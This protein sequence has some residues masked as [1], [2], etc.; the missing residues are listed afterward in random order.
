MIQYGLN[1][2]VWSSPFQ[3]KDLHFLD[4]GKAMGLD[5]VEIPIESIGDWTSPRAREAYAA[6]RPGLQHLR[7]HG[8][9][10]R[11]VAPG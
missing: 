3:T 1:T 7:R 10:P 9:G 2:F 8:R 6:D 4:H 11:P 5:L